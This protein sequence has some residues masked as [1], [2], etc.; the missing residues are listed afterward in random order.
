MSVQY[1][2]DPDTAMKPGRAFGSWASVVGVLQPPIAHFITLPSWFVQYTLAQSTAM[3]VG[4]FCA[5]VVR[6]VRLLQP[7]R[8]HCMT[9]PSPWFVQ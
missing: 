2:V 6:D 4:A 9:V 5:A 3:P 7:G 8:V 1:A